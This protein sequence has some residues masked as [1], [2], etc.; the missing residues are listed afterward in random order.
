[1]KRKFIANICTTIVVLTSLLITSCQ[2]REELPKM[3]DV[4]N[5][6]I[7]LKEQIIMAN[8]V[9]AKKWSADNLGYLGMVYYSSNYYDRA[10][11]CFD[12]AAEKS[13]KDWRWNYYLAFLK[14][15]LGESEIALNH[16][17]RVLEIN[18]DVTLATYRLAA[19]YRQKNKSEEA[20]TLLKELLERRLS[21]FRLPTTERTAYYP[22]PNYARYL[23]SRIYTDEKNYGEAEKELKKIISKDKTFGPAYKQLG[24]VY[25]AMG[26]SVKSDEYTV[27]SND[28]V[29]YVDPVDTLMDRL[30]LMSK[31]EIFL[32]KQVDNAIN[33]FDSRWTYEILRVALENIPNN[34]YLIAK[35]VRQMMNM[36]LGHLVTSYLD[37]HF[38]D[39]KDSWSEM[40]STAI[41]L[42]DAGFKKEAQR[43]FRQAMLQNPT[44]IKAKS[45]LAGLM[46]QKGGMENQAYEY[47]QKL[48]KEFPDDENVLED[49]IFMFIS[50]NKETEAKVY[51]M[52]LENLTPNSAPL[53]S[54][55]GYQKEVEGSW[56]KAIAFYEASLFK[57]EGSE[58]LV[59]RVGAIYERLQ[60]WQ[61]A[62]TFYQQA[63]KSFPNRSDLQE[64]LGA[65]LVNCPDEQLINLPEGINNA[66]RAFYN[67]IYTL[68]VKVSAARTLAI[69]YHI[70]GDDSQSGYYFNQ[71]IQLAKKAKLAPEYIQSLAQLAHQWGVKF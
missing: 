6:S 28:L 7:G 44:N 9:V 29:L 66:E 5:L 47:M 32:L 30:A 11:K 13:R 52:R 43:F 20:K 18:P 63:L 45:T 70:S 58:F 33:G 55:K 64:R 40:Q 23:L 4:K 49:A 51:L 62:I 16:L 34:K 35:A 69:A 42:S 65:I 56:K 14:I 48:L 21:D 24:L 60:E 38:D 27:R 46:H 1:M 19:I 22:L 53:L 2:N 3:P 8:K 50:M 36:G 71:A 57:D 68:P 25:S 15:E 12:L 10:A 39:F 61:K 17:K 59:N 26:D 41:A 67:S 37:Q 54:L 31:S